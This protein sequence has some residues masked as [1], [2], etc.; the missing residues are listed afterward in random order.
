MPSNCAVENCENK[1]S[2][3]K[4]SISF[5]SFPLHDSNLC[6]Q[7]IRALNLGSFQPTKHSRV[8]SVHFMSSDFYSLD[9]QKPKLKKDAIPIQVFSCRPRV[10]PRLIK[11]NAVLMDAS[12][13]TDSIETTITANELYLPQDLPEDHTS[14][15]SYGIVISSVSSVQSPKPLNNLSISTEVNLIR[16]P[17]II[18]DK[19]DHTYNKRRSFKSPKKKQKQ[20]YIAEECELS[21]VKANT[22]HEQLLDMN[23]V[24]QEHLAEDFAGNN[25]D[26]DIKCTKYVLVELKQLLKLCNGCLEDGCQAPLN[27]KKVISTGDVITIR[28]QCKDDHISHL[29]LP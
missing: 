17:T 7:W 13:Q 26:E 4:V 3:P 22:E 16:P 10:L 15:E 6:K 27:A 23:S 2:N 18:T 14:S 9:C 20:K 8:C 5:H 24:T 25:F 29:G 28:L 12:T 21:L 1:R 11:P 19:R